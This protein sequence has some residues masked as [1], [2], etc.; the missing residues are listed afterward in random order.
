MNDDTQT[1]PRPPSSRSAGGTRKGLET[2]ARIIKGAR[3]ALENDGIEAVTTRKIASSAKVRLATLHYYFDSKES[4]LLA[5]LQDMIDDMASAYLP[6]VPFSQDPED[7]IAALIRLIWHY[8][9]ET[10][11]RQLA[12]IELTLYALRT[13]GAEWL[14]ERQYQA[15][16][17]FY[18]GLIFDDP[19]VSEEI[20]K[21][22]GAAI[23]RFILI[24]I[25]GL[26]LQ[27]FA[28]QDDRVA[29]ESVETLIIATRDYLARLKKAENIG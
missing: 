21:R 15:Y 20:R 6:A 23:A 7:R 11:E 1:L 29:N 27:S 16:I 9:G 24:G 13:R 3:E 14:A 2:R 19:E 4:L 26:I 18:G 17:D 25:D 22:I 12:Q 8:I 28:L 5:V 10:R